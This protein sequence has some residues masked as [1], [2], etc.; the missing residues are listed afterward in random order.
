LVVGISG[1]ASLLLAHVGLLL[2]H[3]HVA[4]ASI[5][6]VGLALLVGGRWKNTAS[7]IGQSSD[8]DESSESRVSEHPLAF[9]KKT[10]YWG[11]ILLV[12][13]IPI[14]FLTKVL[15]V[16]EA[17]TQR[18]AAPVAR[19]EKPA[20]QEAVPVEFPLLKLSGFVCNGPKSTAVVN[21]TTLQVGANFE[22]VRIVAIE[23]SGVIVE[24]GGCQKRLIQEE[25]TKETKPPQLRKSAG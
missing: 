14:F 9:F 10:G 5:A 25:D 17:S 21:G 16:T 24:M 2:P 3:L 15:C 19:V 6:V 22:G 1:A 20:V 4:V 18:N 8:T 11:W 7:T 13:A 12:S 23:P